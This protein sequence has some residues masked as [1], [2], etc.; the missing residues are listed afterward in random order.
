MVHQGCDAFSLTRKIFVMLFSHPCKGGVGD[1]DG[2]IE[3]GMSVRPLS[4][5][6]STASPM[7]RLANPSWHRPDHDQHEH[8]AVEI[9]YASAQEPKR[10]I[11][12][13]AFCRLAHCTQSQ[14]RH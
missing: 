5:I 13:R 1:D 2:T 10:S 4:E 3:H 11:H 7:S 6:T 12:D 14:Q 9:T 8:D